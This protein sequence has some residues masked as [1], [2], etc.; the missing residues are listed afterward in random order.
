MVIKRIHVLYH[1]EAPAESQEVIK[2]VHE[3]HK[4]YCPVYQ[5]IKKSI[6]VTTAYQ[7]EVD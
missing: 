5:S 1:I 4:N 2:R 6:E 3:L 7:L